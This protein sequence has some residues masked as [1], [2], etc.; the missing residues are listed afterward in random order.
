[1][2]LTRR[3]LLALPA[4]V[5][6]TVVY[7]AGVEPFFTTVRR[8]A[9]SPPGWPKGTTLKVAALADIHACDP[10]MGVGH[11]ER[12]VDETNRLGADVIV[13]LGDYVAAHDKVTSYVADRD[14][15][16]A[17]AGLK[18]PLGV[19]A[20]L[21]N[22]DWWADEAVQSGSPGLPR[23]GRALESA[24]IRVLHNE[25]VRLRAPAGGF[26]SLAGLGDQWAYR[27]G[28]RY[29]HRGSDNL[30]STLDQ[31]G[32]G[33]IV[34]LVHEPDIFP[35]VPGRVSLTL[36]GH[37]HGGQVQVFNKALIVPSIYGDRYL[38]G[39][40]VED[41]RHMV[42]SAGLGCSWWPVRIG[43]PPEIVVVDLSA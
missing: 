12:I 5:A 42:V 18:A 41:D 32:D 19:Y 11:I 37:T 29:R 40:I 24:G 9:L 7:G 20:I 28:L 6:G 23:A 27:T 25:N 14:W 16:K 15:A 38:Q 34:L 13:L 22:H 21:G 3:S 8:Y 43:V 26:V 36:A 17:L 30:A 2:L 1:V 31:T 4:I 39:H 10:W 35:K 33:P